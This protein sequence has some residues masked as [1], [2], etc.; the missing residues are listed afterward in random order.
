M[1][2]SKTL[3]NKRIING[4]AFY[5]WANSA[6]F[7]VISTAIFPSYFIANTTEYIKFFGYEI[8]NSAFYSFLV[9][10]AYII[11]AATTPVLSGMADYSGNRKNFLKA[12]TLFG[13]LGCI[14]LFWFLNEATMWVG[15]I[16]FVVATVGCAGSLVFYDSFLPD[17]ASEDQYDKVSARGYSF[18]YIGSVILLLF[19]LY[20][21]MNPTFFGISDEKLPYRIGFILVGFWWISFAQITF[22]TLPQYRLK[23]K[24]TTGMFVNGFKELRKA[25]DR[26]KHKPQTRRYLYAFFFYFSGVQT[27]VYLA[28]A[29]ASKVLGFEATELIIIILILQLIAVPGAY[30]F[31][32]IAKLRSNKFSMLLMITIWAGICIAASFVQDKVPFYFLAGLVGL[33]LGGIQSMS[34]STYTKMLD[35]EESDITC[36]YSFYDFLYKLSV[37]F[38][39]ALFAILEIVFNDMRAS[40]MGLAVLFVIA[41]VILATV[42]IKREPTKAY[43]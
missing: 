19:I 4:W 31:A 35:K 13:S 36:Y 20:M 39:T 16:A 8:A 29:F 2:V 28:S 11:I 37:V 32:H 17:I 40:V 25:F 42:T 10:I 24:D 7:L 22:R 15:I 43:S 12:F 34:R 38:G 3:N 21:A 33:V 18:G 5:D 6:Y 14:T 9:S 27:V 41:F 23:R 1:E 30:L 26:L